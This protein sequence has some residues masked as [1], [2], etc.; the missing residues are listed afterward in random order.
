DAPVRSSPTASA[1]SPRTSVRP[2]PES[3]TRHVSPPLTVAGTVT[4]C[5][6]Y[7][8]LTSDTAR[9]YRRLAIALLDSARQ[10]RMVG[11]IDADGEAVHGLAGPGKLVELRHQLRHPLPELRRLRLCDAGV[12]DEAPQLPVAVGPD[13]LPCGDLEVVEVPRQVVA[14]LTPL[15]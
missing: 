13:R 3:R 11:G 8:N 9:D 6:R 5:W 12:A 7:S 1:S 2:M 4:R 14:L 10:C 15:D